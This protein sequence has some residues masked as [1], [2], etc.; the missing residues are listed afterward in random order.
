M[1][2]SGTILRKLRH[3]DGDSIEISVVNDELVGLVVKQGPHEVCQLAFTY[4]ELTVLIQNLR[5]AQRKVKS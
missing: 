1:K 3:P 4:D 2:W 5:F